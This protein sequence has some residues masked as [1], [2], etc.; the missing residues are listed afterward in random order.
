MTNVFLANY[1]IVLNDIYSGIKPEWA[2]PSADIVAAEEVLKVKLPTALSELYQ[3]CGNFQRL[4]KA[5][6]RMREPVMRQ[7]T[8]WRSGLPLERMGD[9]IVF[10]EEN[11]CVSFYSFDANDPE[12]DPKVYV[13]EDADGPWEEWGGSLTEFLSMQLH[14][15]LGNGG[16]PV[17]GLAEID[18]S[19]VQLI[20]KQFPAAVKLRDNRA[21]VEVFYEDGQ[22]IVVFEDDSAP[23]GYFMH[24]GV[25]SE[26]K[27]AELGAKLQIDEWY[28]NWFPGDG[29]HDD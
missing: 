29:T 12:S 8:S 18:E 23:D 28:D 17:G 9:R 20:R 27:F 16:A 5:C 19:T 22:S 11:E 3:L 13:G 25:D 7:E 4:H 24:C 2:V 6:D 21:A 14:W 15:Q 1:A 26:E 10:Y